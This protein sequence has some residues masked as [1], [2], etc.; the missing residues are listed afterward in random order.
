MKKLCR[1]EKGGG[2]KMNLKIQWM[3]GLVRGYEGEFENVTLKLMSY[4]QHECGVDLL[5]STIPLNMMILTTCNRKEKGNTWDIYHTRD[6]GGICVCI[7]MHMFWWIWKRRELVMGEIW[8][9]NL[10]DY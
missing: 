5:K 2:T 1:K 8:G 9:L 7:Y 10:L 3:V 4:V 6:S